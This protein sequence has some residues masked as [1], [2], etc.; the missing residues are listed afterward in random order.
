MSHLAAAQCR[1]SVHRRVGAVEVRKALEV[2]DIAPPRNT[3]HADIDRRET[4]HSEGVMLAL[5]AQCPAPRLIPEPQ[6]KAGDGEADRGDRRASHLPRRG[7]RARGRALPCW[8][9][10]PKTP[11]SPT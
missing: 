3:R 5:I 10:A 4:G 2:V 8:W 7:T 1:F 6:G 9:A 11:P